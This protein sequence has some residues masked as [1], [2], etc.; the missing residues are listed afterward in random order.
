MRGS[1]IATP[2][3]LVPFALDATGA[4]LMDQAQLKIWAYAGF[5]ALVLLF[6]VLDL[7]VFHR[8]AHEVSMKEALTWSTIW[9]AC[10]TG[11]SAFL[12]AGLILEH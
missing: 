6:L 3:L 11:F 7:G 5:I 1:L 10:G 12:G 2:L 4:G 9:L 8:D